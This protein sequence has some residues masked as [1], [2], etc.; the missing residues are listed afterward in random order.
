MEGLVSFQLFRKGVAAAVYVD[1]CQKARDITS[2]KVKVEPLRDPLKI[3]AIMCNMKSR[4]RRL[5]SH[6]E[7]GKFLQAQASLEPDCEEEDTLFFP[8][9]HEKWN[10]V[11]LHH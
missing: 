2:L 4:R 5:N 9:H 10:A 1:I 8:F 11:A 6:R 7:L 3:Y